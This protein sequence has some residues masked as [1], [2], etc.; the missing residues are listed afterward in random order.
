VLARERVM[1]NLQSVTASL[2]QGVGAP[3]YTI[4]IADSTGVYEVLADSSNPVALNTRWM[5]PSWAYRS[6]R[7]PAS[8]VG[9]VSGNN[10]TSFF[11]T[12]ARRIDDDNVIIVNGY[13]GVTLGNAPFEGEVVQVDGAF[14]SGVVADIDKP[15]FSVFAHNLGFNF[16]SIKLLFG[17]VEGT[18]GLSLPVFADRR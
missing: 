1:T 3:I 8:A 11:P 15:G 18:R 2:I 13:N 12:Y 9:V 14:G 16:K 7:R 5:L 10:P 6:M 17:P 4:M